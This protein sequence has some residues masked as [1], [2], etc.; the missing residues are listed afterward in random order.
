MDQSDEQRQQDGAPP[1]FLLQAV[2][3]LTREDRRFYRRVGIGLS[4]FCLVMPLVA[5]LLIPLSWPYWTFSAFGVL[6]GFCFLW[7]EMGLRLLDVIPRTL[8]RVWRGLR[9]ERRAR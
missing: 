4:G 8:S 3:R 9:P 1:T 7:P 2:Q 5:D 6:A